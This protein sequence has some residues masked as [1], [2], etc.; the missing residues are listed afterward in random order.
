M[1][2]KAKIPLR[3]LVICVNNSGYAASL[4]RFKLYL[5]VRDAE[6]EKHG[7]VR[8]VD[9]SGEGYLYPRKFF[10]AVPQSKAAASKLK[11]AIRMKRKAA[12]AA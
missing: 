8:I 12:K 5:A 4:E 10:I 7:L 6:A 2:P 1:K 3:E 11:A 9:E